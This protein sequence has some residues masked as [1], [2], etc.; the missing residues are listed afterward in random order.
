MSIDDELI[1]QDERGWRHSDKL[2]CASCVGDPHLRDAVAT[3]ADPEESCSFC[4]S[5]PAAEFDVFM[6]AF[7]VG[8][9]NEF[10]Q[11]DNAGMPWDGGYV[12]TTYDHWDIPDSFDDVAS[13]EH[14]EEVL[15]TIRD[16]L[17]DKVYASRWWIA[18]EPD[19]A[20]SSAWQEF[21]DQIQHHTRFVFGATTHAR[22]DGEGAGEVPVAKVLESIG[23]L[24]LEFGLVRP[25]P[26]GTLIQRARG[27][28][29]PTDAVSWGAAELGT[30]SPENS[31]SSSRMSPA[32]IPLFYGADTIETALAEVARADNSEYFT[33]A[34][35][36][37][38]TD[39]AVVDL[40][41][42]PSVPSVFD[43]VRGARRREIVFLNALVA[44]LRE[45]IDT[46][47]SQL[48]YV[49]TQVFCEY[50][51]RVF[52]AG[53][54]LRGIAWNSAV[55]EGLCLAL[56]VAHQDCIDNRD[57]GVVKLQLEIET[58][59]ITVH[60]RRSDEFRDL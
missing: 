7:M 46:A 6:E 41:D 11:A 52:D 48:D 44:Q 32:G 18:L 9:N 2:I 50:L 35:F 28:R 53:T 43:S 22:A 13:D 57:P 25:L 56:D 21:C 1:E 60:Q 40:T 33:S 16:S 47:R 27:H 14:A 45:P 8:V 5:V 31:T 30:N 17:V 19:K 42:V 3:A 26:A 54:P 49:P 29:T 34:Q 20:F 38:T 23:E 58:G 36:R 4:D 51:L 59:S 24:L 10:E 12:F 39:A 37:T 15:D 55:T